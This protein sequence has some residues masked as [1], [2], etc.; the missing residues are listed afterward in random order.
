MIFKCEVCDYYKDGQ[1]TDV[2]L[3]CTK[4]KHVG[5][6]NFTLDVE[7]YQDYEQFASPGTFESLYPV[8]RNQGVWDLINRLDWREAT[9]LTQYYFLEMT[10]ADIAEYHNESQQNISIIIAKSIEKI[11]KF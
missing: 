4:Y 2:C 9:M 3:K 8:S 1:G 6:E 7:Y 10:Q 5:R 11:R